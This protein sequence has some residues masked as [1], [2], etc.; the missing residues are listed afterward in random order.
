LADLWRT[1]RSI[2]RER[3]DVVFFP[4]AYTYVPVTGAGCVAVVIHDVIAEHFPE[5]VFP[6]RRAALLWWLKLL[7]A[8]RQADLI[9][10]VS[11]ASRRAIL[12]RFGIP[13]ERVVVISE[14]ADAAF[15]RLAHDDAMRGVLARWQLGHG[16]YL[17][18]VGGMSPHK[19]LG[20]LLDAFAEVRQD[21][22]CSDY[23]LVF[24]GDFSGDVFYSAHDTLRRHVAL[25]G[26][27]EAVTFTG[28]LDDEV[29][30]YLYNGAA[31]LVL[32]SLWEGFGLPVIEAMACGTPVVASRAGALPEVVGTAGLLFDPHQRTELQA[33][34]LRLLTDTD[35]QV[36][37]RRL[38]LQR[39]AEFSWERAAQQTVAAFRDVARMREP[40][41]APVAG[42]TFSK[43]DDTR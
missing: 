31:A 37:L 12:A 15:R 42:P 28:H 34:L 16:R 30:A 21:A 29:L 36:R 5:Q 14:A 32:P 38:G 10:T 43:R 6:T 22:R 7:A 33:A 4:S 25:R 20:V 23:R 1:S 8:R 40:R 35:L 2:S 13:P 11:E 24:V 3:F 17:L 27:C 19:N 26:L 41:A 39:A 9:L 18:Y